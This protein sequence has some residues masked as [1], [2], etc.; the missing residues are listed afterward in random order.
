MRRIRIAFRADWTHS[1]RDPAKG[2]T[3]RTDCGEFLPGP[4]PVAPGDVPTCPP[5][6]GHLAARFWIEELRR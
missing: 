3:P 4:R 6:A 5:C 2:S 1:R